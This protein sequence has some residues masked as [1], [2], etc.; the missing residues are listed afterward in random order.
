[1]I[2]PTITLREKSQGPKGT[3]QTDTGISGAGGGAREGRH[4]QATGREWIGNDAD[5]KVKSYAKRAWFVCEWSG[6]V[7]WV[8]RAA[9]K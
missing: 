3:F 6:A 8:G 2:V 7:R 5:L 1:M 4:L 9:A